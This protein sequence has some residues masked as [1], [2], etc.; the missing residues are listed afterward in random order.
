MSEPPENFFDIKKHTRYIAVVDLRALLSE[1]FSAEGR[2]RALEA[3]YGRSM[4]A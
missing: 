1:S 2:K 4:K 3:G